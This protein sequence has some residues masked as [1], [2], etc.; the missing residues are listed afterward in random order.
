MVAIRQGPEAVCAAIVATLQTHLN[1]AI[2]DVWSAWASSDPS[3]EQT[4]PKPYPQRIYK[5]RRRVVDLGNYPAIMV[6]PAPSQQI[7]NHMSTF[8]GSADA[9]DVERH[10]VNVLVGCVSDDLY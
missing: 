8:A 2:D 9:Y 1:A 5:F 6:I 10:R 7:A 4:P 3:G